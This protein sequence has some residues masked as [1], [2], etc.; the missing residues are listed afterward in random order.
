MIAIIDYGMGNIHSVQKALELMGGSTVVT[1][2]LKDIQSA[3]KLVLP[4]VGAFTEAM[5]ELE[6]QE[7]AAAIKDQMN[8]KKPFLGICLGMQ[9]LFQESKEGKGSR[10]LSVL[11]GTVKRFSNNQGLKVPHM[12]WDEVT[13][14]NKNCP[15]L[16]GINEDAYV[17]FCHSYYPEP[18]ENAVTAASCK[19][20]K[21]FSCVV[22]QDNVYGVQFHPE[23]SQQVGLKMLKN[24]VQLC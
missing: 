23:K 20:G 11:D 21:E 7:L 17:Y 10:G 9:L 13:I 8:N 15:L 16:K 19:Y 3:E 4:G 5:R 6:K 14:K 2:R 18:A 22:W 12:G 24:F 1:N